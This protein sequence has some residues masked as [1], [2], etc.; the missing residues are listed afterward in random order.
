MKNA[1]LSIGMIFA[2]LFGATATAQ[3]QNEIEPDTNILFE[4]KYDIAPSF[5]GGNEALWECIQKHIDYKRNVI[6]GNIYVTFIIDT[7]GSILEP[8]ALNDPGRGSA[9]QAVK[10]V[11]QLPKWTPASMFGHPV[12]V[13]CTL[14]VYFDYE[15]NHLENTWWQEPIKVQD[16]INPTNLQETESWRFISN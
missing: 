6:I 16:P 2:F 12:N 15:K 7:N 8:K 1:L 11:Q 3:A 9:K 4:G 5:P 13:K 14:S 10:V